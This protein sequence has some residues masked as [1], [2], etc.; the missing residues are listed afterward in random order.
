MSKNFLT[1]AQNEDFC[2]PF[3]GNLLSNAIHIEQLGDAVI[4]ILSGY[5]GS[6]IYN[7]VDHTHHT[8]REV[9]DWH[10]EAVGLP[11]VPGM[12]I[13]KSQSIKTQY[14]EQKRKTIPLRLAGEVV[15][16]MRSAPSQLVFACPSIRELTYGVLLRM[17]VAWERQVKTI[18]RRIAVDRDIQSG[19][20][21][22]LSVSPEP[23]LLSDPMPGPYFVLSRASSK[24]NLSQEI[25]HKERL[26]RWFNKWANPNGAWVA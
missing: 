16:W 18:Y 8:W 24:W 12:S 26:A 7:L 4:D 3:D 25:E 14:L 9:F 20:L 2:L 6:G 17:P 19:F 13:E 1:W 11:A 23:W 15:R 22:D 10:T 21:S 5:Q